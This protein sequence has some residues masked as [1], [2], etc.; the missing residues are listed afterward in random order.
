MSTQTS[1]PINKVI[2]GATR[3][4]T[5]FARIGI[6]ISL[7][8]SFNPSAIACSVP[9]NPVTF[10][11]FRRWI[12]AKTLRSAIVKNAIANKI[13]INVIKSSTI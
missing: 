9:Q 12:D 2:L 6:T 4:K 1:N 11:P 10:G 5:Q 13:Q 7:K 8:I 3:N